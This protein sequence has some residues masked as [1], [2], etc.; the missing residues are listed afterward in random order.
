MWPQLWLVDPLFLDVWVFL[1]CCVYFPFRPQIRLE[2]GKK[3]RNFPFVILWP[4]DF[5]SKI[6]NALHNI[7]IYQNSVL[8]IGSATCHFFFFI[9]LDYTVT[10]FFFLLFF[11]KENLTKQLF[12]C[13][14]LT[15]GGDL[16]LFMF[17]NAVIECWWHQDLLFHFLDYWGIAVSLCVHFSCHQSHNSS[18]CFF[19]IHFIYSL[20]LYCNLN[21]ITPSSNQIVMT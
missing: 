9:E 14:T 13:F 7:R 6:P 1:N 5:P 19:K 18:V 15:S 21:K 12:L 16:Y 8:L 4:I 3:P 10:C 17:Q 20:N 11:C 2:G